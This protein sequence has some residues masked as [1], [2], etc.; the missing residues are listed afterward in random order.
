MQSQVMYQGQ[1]LNQTGTKEGGGFF[2]EPHGKHYERVEK[3]NVYIA[4]TPVAG[5]VFPAYNATAQVFGLWNQSTDKKLVPM[6]FTLNHIGTPSVS[7]SLGMSIV[8][9]G[10]KIATG[11]ISVFTKTAPLNAKTLLAQEAPAGKLAFTATTVA[12]AV[13]VP[14]GLSCSDVL[15]A[16]STTVPWSQL[17]LDFEDGFFVQPGICIFVCGDVAQTAAFSATLSWEEVPI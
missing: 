13:H 4:Y 5:V 6:R 11:N 7:G 16:A 12:P 15:A 10:Q 1:S 3:G 8:E 14:F 17:V 2:A 9:A